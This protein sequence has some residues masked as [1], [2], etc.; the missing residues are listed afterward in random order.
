M[1]AQ[2]EGDM[3]NNS[4]L[5]DGL[6]A[7]A[8]GKIKNLVYSVHE[9]EHNSVW[10]QI[11]ASLIKQFGS[12]AG[13]EVIEVGAGSGTYGAILARHGAK[14]TVL[15]YSANALQVSRELYESLGIEAT[16]ILADALAIGD[17]LKAKYD[18]SMS[19]GLAEHFADGQRL[20]IIRSHFDLIKPSGMTLISVPNLECWPY[21]FWK[22]QRTI[23]GKWDF[24]LELPYDQREFVDISKAI[25]VDKY[26]F[27]G[28]S[29]W[30]SFLFVLPLKR[31]RNSFVKRF[32]KHKWQ[33]IEALRQKS[34]GVF[35]S[36]YG[37]AL[38]Y[39]AIRPAPTA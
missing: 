18:V 4:A 10:P 17:D 12:I 8:Q 9:E 3:K 21:R 19:F 27:I 37:Y 31:W 13:L 39:V 34:P 2:K 36:R 15:D 32:Q 20:Q 25:A 24:G 30:D 16:F 35:D 11:K 38:I 33:N 22:F 14:V 1:H 23:R 28:S 5:W 26:S 29:F 6:W 7:N